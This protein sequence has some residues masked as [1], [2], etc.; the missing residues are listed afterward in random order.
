MEEHDNKQ[1][2]SI[3]QD[4]DISDNMTLIPEKNGQHQ[5]FENEGRLLEV[6][7]RKLHSRDEENN[8]KD[9]FLSPS[10]CKIARH[11]TPD[12]SSAVKDECDRIE[13]KTLKHNQSDFSPCLNLSLPTSATSVG[14]NYEDK[15]SVANNDKNALDISSYTLMFP[16]TSRHGSISAA[17]ISNNGQVQNILVLNL[18]PGV[19]AVLSDQPSETEENVLITPDMGQ[20]LQEVANMSSPSSSSSPSCTSSSNPQVVCDT[21]TKNLLNGVDP[22]ESKARKCS[23]IEQSTGRV[24]FLSQVSPEGYV[25]NTP[26]QNL[27]HSCSKIPLSASFSSVSSSTSLR[28][29][30]SSRSPN[31]TNID[32]EN[33]QKFKDHS[34]E[35]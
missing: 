22:D 17:P 29:D 4:D 16:N 20:G 11:E 26:E 32:I 21:T 12:L 9:N 8:V 34:K 24:K 30:E 10:P 7:S 25:F 6:V 2:D 33:W 28:N 5:F 13:E 15:L 1:L 14:S 3:Q 35:K 18:P 23:G 27:V 31:S 19:N